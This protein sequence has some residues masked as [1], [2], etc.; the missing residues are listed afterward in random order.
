VRQ[1]QSGGERCLEHGLI[2]AHVQA[3]RVRLDAYRVFFGAHC[4][5]PVMCAD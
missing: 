4:P 2:L 3:A 5:R 1:I